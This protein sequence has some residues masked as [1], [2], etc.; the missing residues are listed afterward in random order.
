MKIA[1]VA[2]LMESVPPRLYGGTERIV[3]YLTEELVGLGHDVT[4]FASGDSI[5]SAELAPCCTRA[6]RLDPTVRDTIPHFMV[7]IDKV[8][9]RAEEFD[10]LHFHVDLFHFPL[11]SALAARTL[12]TLHGRQDLADLKPFY[13][14]FGEMP[15]VSISNDQRKPLPH[16][17]F[18]ATIH[19]GIPSDLHRPSFEQGRYLAFLGRISPEKRPDRAIRIARAAGIPL[20]IAAKVDKVDEDYFRNDILP[21]IDGPGVE[22]IGEINEREKTKFLG[23]AAAL[24]F[25]VDWPEPFGLVMI[26]AMACG[27]PVL[28]FRCGSIPEVIDDGVTGKVVDSEEDANTALLEILSYDRRAVRQR[29]EERF[30]ANRMAKAYVST[31]RQ[32]LMTRTSA[33]TLGQLALKGGN[34]VTHMS[35]EK[36]MPT[37]IGAGE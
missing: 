7:M 6:L 2:P 23:D 17:N 4:L 16:A 29:Y 34:G 1:Q 8:R 10:V 32:L 24:L 18:V 33:A 28:A 15:L 25:P 22:F 36:P 3:S 12:T 26:E 35:I 5:T 20:K 31:Y 19:H 11:F 13:S 14:R 30:T 27:T 21:L 37:L 9:E